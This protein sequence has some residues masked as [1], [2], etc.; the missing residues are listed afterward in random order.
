MNVIVVD[1]Q[2][3]NRYL[4]KSLLTSSGHKVEEAANGKIA[5]EIL[6]EGTW[7]LVISDIFMP[8]MDGYQL[9]RE[10]RSSDRLKHLPFIFYTATYV[11]E[12][13]EEFALK[14]GADRFYRKPVD[15]RVF[16]D[17]I[18][19]LMEEIAKAPDRAR[20][21]IQA[22]EKEILKLYSERLVNKLELKMLSLEKE[23]AER[24]R[25]EE[26]LMASLQEKEVLLQEVHHRVKNNMQVISSLFNLQVNHTADGECRRILIEG[27][28]RIRSMSLVHEQLYRS[29]DLSRIDLAGYIKGLAAHLFSVYLH[30]STRV[31]MEANF[32]ELLLDINSAIP[33]GLILNEL[34]SNAIKH[35]FPGDRTGLVRI[36][37][38]RTPEGAVELRVADDGVGLPEGLDIQKAE[39]LGLQIVHLLIEQLE[40]VL[41]VDR[42]RGTAVTLTFREPKYRP[43]V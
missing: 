8:V 18:R 28:T 32:E 9:C 23:V 22:D 4:L 12:K 33:C 25:T 27:Q 39:T 38:R 42:T 41:E 35:A 40:G 36:G 21:A 31:R 7:D 24:K 14:L 26:A 43:R 20:P 29:R 6:A 1:D 34:I 37:L 30:D 10:I 15:L 3:D 16:M 5:L 19:E 2:A 17:N 13:D 11:D